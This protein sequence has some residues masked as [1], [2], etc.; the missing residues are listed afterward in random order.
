MRMKSAP[1]AILLTRSKFFISSNIQTAIMMPITPHQSMLFVPNTGFRIR[2]SEIAPPAII[3]AVQPTSCSTLSAAQNFAPC[4]PKESLT[5]SIAPRP[6]SPPISAARYMR[7]PPIRCPATTAPMPR[8][9]PSGAI[10]VPVYISA[11]ETAAPNQISAFA[12]VVLFSS[13]I[14]NTP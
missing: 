2:P 10:S 1:I 8:A 5:L 13:F 6:E 3:T 12:V 7:K 11:M 9:I 14:K 4:S